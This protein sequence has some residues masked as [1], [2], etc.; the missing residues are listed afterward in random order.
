MINESENTNSTFFVVTLH[1]S[2]KNKELL[3]SN[4]NLRMDVRRN[5]DYSIVPSS[6]WEEY[7]S[8]YDIEIPISNVYN[9][10]IS[11][12]CNGM[13]YKNM[14]VHGIEKVFDVI[15][16]LFVNKTFTIDSFNRMFIVKWDSNIIDPMVNFEYFGDSTR[17]V[18]LGVERKNR[19][20]DE[21]LCVMETTEINENEIATKNGVLKEE[22]SSFKINHSMNNNTNNNNT[23]NNNTINNDMNRIAEEI[24]F[25]KEL[26]S[27]PANQMILMQKSA[28]ISALELGSGVEQDHTQTNYDDIRVNRDGKFDYTTI[29]NFKTQGCTGIMNIGNSCYIS[30]SIQCLN[31][32]S[33]FSNFFVFFKN[34][35]IDSD[36]IPPFTELHRNKYYRK[37]VSL[38]EAW[39]RTISDYRGN[40][41]VTPRDLKQAI[42]LKNDAFDNS[43]EQDAAE[44]IEALLTYLHEGLC[45]KKTTETVFNETPQS[46]SASFENSECDGSTEDSETLKNEFRRLIDADRSIISELFY[47]MF[48]NT[49]K[50]CKCGFTKR[51]NDLM[52]FLPLSIPNKISYHSSSTLIMMESRPPIKILIPLNF[53]IQEAIEYTKIEYD[54]TNN[55]I[56][57]EYGDNGMIHIIPNLRSVN[58]INNSIC[59]YEIKSNARLCICNMYYM[60]FYFIKTKICFDFIFEEDHIKINLYEKLKNY[61]VSNFTLEEFMSNVTIKRGKFNTVL[62]VPS[63][64]VVFKDINKLFGSKFSLLSVNNQKKKDDV[65]LRDCL[66]YNFKEESANVACDRCKIV[67]EF[68]MTNRL[69]QYPKYLIIHLKR[70]S[71][72]GREAKIN[73]FI[74]FP[75]N[76]LKIDETKFRLIATANHIEIG[77][78]C[79]HYISYLRKDNGWYCCNDSVISKVPGPDKSSCYILFYEKIDPV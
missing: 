75:E 69:S 7:Q 57:V 12:S 53:T 34:R 37:N 26:Y 33:V 39:V 66:N 11:F 19:Y 43:K 31:N 21:Q 32:C 9:V 51:K 70:F 62:N 58:S 2:K 78:G 35:F 46:L 40:T 45:Y 30:A 76:N 59:F 14:C 22:Q 41:L 10:F 50:C 74:D 20:S 42:S 13:A 49:M 79:G 6:I 38:I 8:A 63:I 27:V 64:E 61:F 72:H 56:A 73:T 60:K 77:L 3:D 25:F 52:M 17:K 44:F 47:G 67:T 54:I 71:Y 48:T 1:S 55:L 24:A 68:K 29:G 16:T 15:Q 28:S 23:M 65:T 5:I 18:I 4:G 36:Q